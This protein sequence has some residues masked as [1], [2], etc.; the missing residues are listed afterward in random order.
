MTSSAATVAGRSRGPYL[1]ASVVLLVIAL[2]AAIFFGV[3]WLLA[4]N[5]DQA[6]YAAARDDALRVGE[7]MAVN[8]T[9]LDYRHM[10][11]TKK[12]LEASTAGALHNQVG[13]TIDQYKKQM[14][15]LKLVTHSTLVEGS[16]VSLD[17]HQNQASVMAVVNST[18]QSDQKNG[19]NKNQQASQRLPIIIG[20]TRANDDAPWKANSVSGAPVMGSGA[21][22]AG[23]PGAGSGSGGS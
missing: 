2:T 5:S 20:L 17:T 13:K 16:V 11:Q 19:N 3:S 8:F 6:K 21:G 15:Q 9:S 23:A 4:A 7:Q 12:T 14:Q 10:D 1:I 22:S 18:K